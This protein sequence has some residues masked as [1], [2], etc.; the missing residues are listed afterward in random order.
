MADFPKATNDAA[1]GPRVASVRESGAFAV[2][3]VFAAPET[4]SQEIALDDVLLMLRGWEDEKQVIQFH[5]CD[6]RTDFTCF[7]FGEI[8]NSNQGLLRIA[9]QEHGFTVSLGSADRF[10]LWDWRDLCPGRTLT[11][12][13]IEGFKEAFDVSLTIAF[14]GGRSMLDLH[15]LK[16]PPDGYLPA[17]PVVVPV[18]S[19]GAKRR[20]DP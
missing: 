19:R 1:P 20:S 14:A 2:I 4:R 15:S 8:E 18:E 7:G 16:E 9:G 3:G 13:E 17:A 6:S 11:I 10:S 5:L 12:D